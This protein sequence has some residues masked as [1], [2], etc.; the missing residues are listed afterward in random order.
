MI[1][2]NGVTLPDLPSDVDRSAYPYAIIVTGGDLGNSYGLIFSKLSWI[3][4][5]SSERIYL[6]LDSYSVYMAGTD[7]WEHSFDDETSL[8]L[9]VATY[10]II[11]SDHNILDSETGEVYFPSSVQSDPL[12]YYNGVRL[13]ELPSDVD[14][15]VYPYVVLSSVAGE[16]NMYAL[17]Y[18]TKKIYF[19]SSENGYFSNESIDVSLYSCTTTV[20]TEF[21]LLSNM[22]NAGNE[23]VISE[24]EMPIIWSNFDI[25]NGSADATEIYL[26]GTEALS[27]DTPVSITLKTL[28]DL[29]DAI[30][31]VTGDST[32]RT[33]SDMISKVKELCMKKLV[34]EFTLNSENITATDT[35]GI[36]SVNEDLQAIFANIFAQVK[37]TCGA[38]IIEQTALDMTCIIVAN[39]VS[40]SSINTVENIQYMLQNKSTTDDC[41]YYALR[42]TAIH[43]SDTNTMSFII[44]GTIELNVKVYTIG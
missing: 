23:M 19:D 3:Y 20:E 10:Q 11:W 37:E 24:D 38:I 32:L 4:Q 12:F 35:T 18:L 43:T 28:C 17:T 26:A 6:K 33:P 8:G 1:E 39:Y 14:R 15:S 2:V 27:E 31:K 42:A 16:E 41:K 36:Y 25:P 5:P 40:E 13:P 22:T 34:G 7:S 30:R 44:N 9:P 29:G 21:S